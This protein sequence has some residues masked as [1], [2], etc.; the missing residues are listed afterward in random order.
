VVTKV[1]MVTNVIT[2]ET[3]VILVTSANVAT[4]KAVVP[5]V[6]TSRYCKLTC[7]GLDGPWIESRWGQDFTHPSRPALGP[8]QFPVQWVPDLFGGKAAGAWR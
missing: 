6:D 2:T 1:T 5:I 4:I 8:I 7:Y 3:I